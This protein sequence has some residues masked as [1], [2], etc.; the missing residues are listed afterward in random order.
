VSNVVLDASALL[1]LLN[2]EPG[3]PAVASAVASGASISAVN[4]AEVVGK[5]AEAG[6]TEQPLRRALDSLALDIVP[7]DAELAYATGL[8][9]PATRPAGLALGDRACLALAMREKA[10][11]LTMDRT[12][13][14]LQLG[15]TVRALR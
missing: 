2:N 11:A 12:W 1:A 4:L 8:L 13:A 10:E 9:R 7:F 6:V 14:Q 15:V 3:S 5:L